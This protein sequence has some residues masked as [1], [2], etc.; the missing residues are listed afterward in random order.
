M[1]KGETASPAERNVV[2]VP[3]EFAPVTPTLARY[4]VARDRI[5]TRAAV[6]SG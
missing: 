3:S 2:P 6:A 5:Q 4:K 1:M